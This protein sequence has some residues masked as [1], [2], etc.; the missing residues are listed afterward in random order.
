MNIDSPPYFTKRLNKIVRKNTK[1]AEKI[2]KQINLLNTN[3][4]HHSLALHKI[5]DPERNLWSMTVKGN[6]RILFKYT[7]EGILL[8]NIG[9]HD[10]VYK[11]YDLYSKT[12]T[13]TGQK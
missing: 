10:K 2:D 6:V 9:N 11:I 13:S 7:D 1:L 4:E 12:G 8:T 3:P 5:N